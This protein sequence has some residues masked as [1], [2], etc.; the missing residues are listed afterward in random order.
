MVN[1]RNQKLSFQQPKKMSKINNFQ[2]FWGQMLFDATALE[3]T[4]KV[5]NFNQYGN[6]T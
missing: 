3:K 5:M 1:N 4:K 6:K 2:E